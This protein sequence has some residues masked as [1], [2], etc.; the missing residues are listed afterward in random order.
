VEQPPVVHYIAVIVEFVALTGSMTSA[1]LLSRLYS[2]FTVDY[3]KLRVQREG[4]MWL[5]KKHAEWTIDCGLTRQEIRTAE[6]RLTELGV[7]ERKVWKFDG[8][9]T[10]HYHLDVEHLKQVL[11]LPATNGMVASNQTVVASNQSITVGSNQPTKIKSSKYRSDAIA[12]QKEVGGDMADKT[13]REVQKEIE[14]KISESPSKPLKVNA[15]NLSLYWRQQIPKYFDVGF[16]KS[17]TMKELGMLS[18]YIKTTGVHAVPAMEWAIRQ[19]S[20][21]RYRVK[22]ELGDETTSKPSVGSL[23]KGCTVAVEG[24]LK[25]QAPVD[26][27][28]PVQISAI[29]MGMDV[30][31][32][33]T[34]EEIA[35]M[36]K[37]VKSHED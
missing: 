32:L 2:W 26:S 16:M 8:E 31:V 6:K 14:K 13:A 28:E 25:A 11:W 33:A 7:L 15:K 9:P 23:L 20:E 4:K 5:A 29:T 19:W 36:L 1:V 24:Y 10:A 18:Q 35:A 30:R 27:P 3:H 21:F 37:S 22:E 12:S 34:K 17:H